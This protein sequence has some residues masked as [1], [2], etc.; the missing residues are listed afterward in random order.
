MNTCPKCGGQMRPGV[1]LESTVVGSPDFVGD[2]AVVTY[3][4]GGP[5]RM[6]K[7]MK[8]KACGWSVTTGE[9]KA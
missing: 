2:D 4:P 6:V 9:V 8:C 5:G 1:A 3:S 7:C